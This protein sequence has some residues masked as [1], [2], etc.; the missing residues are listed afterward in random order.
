MGLRY[1]TIVT[2]SVCLVFAADLAVAQ[3]YRVE[4]IASG[5]NQPSY[6]TQAQNDPANIV[7]FTNE[8]ARDAVQGSAPLMRWVESGVMTSTLERERSFSIYRNTP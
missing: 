7:Y 5:L 8:P 6:L 4:R 1:R 2:T 3:L